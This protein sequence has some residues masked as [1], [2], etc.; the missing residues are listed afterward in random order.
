M[1]C[2]IKYRVFLQILHQAQGKPSE[3]SKAW[4]PRENRPVVSGNWDPMGGPGLRRHSKIWTKAWKILDMSL[5][6]LKSFESWTCWTLKI[7]ELHVRP[8]EFLK[9]AYRFWKLFEIDP[10]LSPSNPDFELTLL[11]FFPFL[12]CKNGRIKCQRDWYERILSEQPLMQEWFVH[13]K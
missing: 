2:T 11:E 12:E 8:F 3:A 1:V 4:S 9:H 7:T 6:S 10:I 13:W 5:K